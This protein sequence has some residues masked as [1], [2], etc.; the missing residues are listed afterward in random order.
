MLSK[1]ILFRSSRR[2]Q[3]LADLILEKIFDESEFAINFHLVLA[4]RKD[5]FN[6]L[7]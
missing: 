7:I 2:I 1:S 3:A 4:E 5:I 6:L